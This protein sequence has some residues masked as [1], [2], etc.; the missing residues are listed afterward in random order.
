MKYSLKRLA[1]LS[2]LSLSVAGAAVW[3]M[4]AAQNDTSAGRTR[5]PNKVVSDPKPLSF[6]VN[7]IYRPSGKGD[8]KP[9]E[10]G[11]VL[12]SGDHYKI[13]FTPEENGYVYIFQIDSGGTV[14]QLFPMQKWQDVVLENNNP[15]R[16]GTTYTLPADNKSFVLDE[17]RGSETIYF[18]ASRK[19]DPDVSKL[20]E[21]LHDA[22]KR[23]NKRLDSS[24][25]QALKTT[26]KTRGPAKIVT[27]PTAETE[28]SW[29][30]QEKFKVSEQRLN[31]I[32]S[33]CVNQ[34]TFTHR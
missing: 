16:A 17:Q 27:D 10:N 25:Q 11:G 29:N 24:A 12:K 30:E 32:C 20:A 6:K 19:Q 26:L 9:L 15:V 14:Y 18:M 2:V 3:H 23:G 33:S 28:V 5:G 8:L 22:R 21:Q 31:N 34:V 13:R 1:G 7:Y 4:A